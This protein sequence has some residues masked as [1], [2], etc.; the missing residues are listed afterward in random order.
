MHVSKTR[1]KQCPFFFFFSFFLF[2]SFFP[3]RFSMYS[4]ELQGQPGSRVFQVISAQEEPN[5]RIHYSFHAIFTEN[6]LNHDGTLAEQFL[7]CSVWFGFWSAFFFKFFLSRQRLF[8][9]PLICFL[10]K[11]GYSGLC[12]FVS[13]SFGRLFPSKTIPGIQ[14]SPLPYSS[15]VYLSLFQMAFASALGTNSFFP[16]FVV[17]VLLLTSEGSLTS[18]VIYLNTRIIFLAPGVMESWG[19][20]SRDFYRVPITGAF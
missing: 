9:S 19:R 5:D 4:A 1:W 7:F 15:V 3:K 17:V 20:L 14:L 8:E 2:F 12:L 11:S 18:S 6:S 16:L 10:P 13:Y